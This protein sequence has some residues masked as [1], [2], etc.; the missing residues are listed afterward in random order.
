MAI[1]WVTSTANGGSD[2]NPG[3]AAS[4]FATLT[5]AKSVAGSSDE[6]R[7]FKTGTALTFTPSAT[8]SCTVDGWGSGCV[9]TGQDGDGNDGQ[10]GCGGAYA[11]A[12]TITFSNGTAYAFAIVA[13]T[14]LTTAC[15]LKQGATTILDAD[16]SVNSIDAD[17]QGRAGL[18]SNCTPTTGAHSGG[19]GNGAGGGAGGPSGAGNP[20]GTSGGGNPTGIGTGG[21]HDQNSPGGDGQY[22]AGGGG[23]GSDGGPGNGGSGIIRLSNLPA[24]SSGTPPFLLNSDMASTFQEMGP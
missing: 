20:N 21:A 8:F 23:A 16:N 15:T 9:G 24:L 13:P 14:L 4:P 12:G 11:T 1:Y 5:H 3:T 22:A 17:T 19:I 18:A 2:S 10:D 6:I 7:V